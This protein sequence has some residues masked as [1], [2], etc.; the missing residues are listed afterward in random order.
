MSNTEQRER[1][2]DR[3]DDATAYARAAAHMQDAADSCEYP[4]AR[5]ARD[6]A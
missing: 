5:A 3:R 1:I 4:D 2:R 6:A